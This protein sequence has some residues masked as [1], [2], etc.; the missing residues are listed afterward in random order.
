MTRR[1]A[2]S[3]FACCLLSVALFVVGLLVGGVW[4]EPAAVW[5]AIA[6]R[7][8]GLIRFIIIENRIPALTTAL[9]SGAALSVAHQSDYI[10]M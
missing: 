4:V 6:G 9:L 2:I 1:A 8:D 7:E 3:L 10:Y 5:N